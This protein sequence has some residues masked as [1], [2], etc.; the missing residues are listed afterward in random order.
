MARLGTAVWRSAR[1]NTARGSILL[2]YL[3]QWKE[4]NTIQT[5]FTQ[6]LLLS[7]VTQWGLPHGPQSDL[8]S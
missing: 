5:T 8:R 3:V 1:A 6:L 4:Q 7:V 2:V